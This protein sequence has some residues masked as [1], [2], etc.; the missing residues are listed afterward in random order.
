[1]KEILLFMTLTLHNSK[2]YHM[3]CQTGHPLAN[4]GSAPENLFKAR[5]DWPIPP[6]PAPTLAPT[7]KTEAPPQVAVIHHA[8]VMPK[9]VIEQCSWAPH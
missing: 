8:M 3:P 5:K 7:V 4:A 6:T 9:K 1:M 2:T